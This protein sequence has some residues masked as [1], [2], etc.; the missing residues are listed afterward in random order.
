MPAAASENTPRRFFGIGLA[1]RRCSEWRAAV[2]RIA[3]ALKARAEALLRQGRRTLRKARQGRSPQGMRNWRNAAIRLEPPGEWNGF[4]K[5][6]HP[7]DGTSRR[8]ELRAELCRSDGPQGPERST[9]YTSA[10]FGMRL[11]RRRRPTGL[12]ATSITMQQHPRCRTHT[13]CSIS[14][15]AA[16][17]CATRTVP[18]RTKRQ[19]GDRISRRQRGRQQCRPHPVFGAH[20]CCWCSWRQGDAKVPSSSVSQN[21]ASSARTPMAM[22]VRS[23]QPIW[24]A[25]V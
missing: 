12:D 15:T 9:G 10:T 14:V 5:P 20:R 11:P 13:R 2:G 3:A 23:Q 6:D 8:L 7:P 19:R 4:S 21:Y 25:N 16:G 22:T 24:L 17:T 18:K 1:N